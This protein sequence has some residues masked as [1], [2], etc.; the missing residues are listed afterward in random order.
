MNYYQ[1]IIYNNDFPC[2]ETGEGTVQVVSNLYTTEAKCTDAAIKEI[3]EFCEENGADPCS[4]E[5]WQYEITC[6]SVVE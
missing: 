4:Q 6:V 2:E 5:T 3:N 1:Y